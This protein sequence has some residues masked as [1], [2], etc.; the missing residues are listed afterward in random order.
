MVFNCLFISAASLNLL[1]KSIPVVLSFRYLQNLKSTKPNTMGG[2]YIVN[3][4]VETPSVLTIKSNVPTSS[5]K[6][7][8][9]HKTR[10]PLP[11]LPLITIHHANQA[12]HNT[13]HAIPPTYP[14]ISQ[15][16]HNARD[17]HVFSTANKKTTTTTSLTSRLTN[18]LSQ[19][20]RT[21]DDKE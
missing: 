13:R 9:Q 8:I 1:L 7:H 3:G 12:S 20:Q 6:G 18:T 21:R 5:T 10:T 17:T 16:T 15:T 4:L 19:M 14:T 11:T 2:G